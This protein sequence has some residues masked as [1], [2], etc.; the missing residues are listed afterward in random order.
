MEILSLSRRTAKKNGRPPLTIAFTLRILINN[1]YRD[2]PLSS[3]RPG[4]LYRRDSL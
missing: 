3:S 2:I 1:L 4:L